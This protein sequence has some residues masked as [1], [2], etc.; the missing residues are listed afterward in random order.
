MTLD[1]VGGIEVTDSGTVTYLA[2]TMN[3]ATGAVLLATWPC[4]SKSVTAGRYVKLT[5]TTFTVSDPT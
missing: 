2:L 3:V 4:T 5:S 1:A